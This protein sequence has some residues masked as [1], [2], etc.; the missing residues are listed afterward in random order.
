MMSFSEFPPSSSQPSSRRPRS[1]W[2][3]G[4]ALLALLASVCLAGPAAWA[5][6]PPTPTPTIAIDFSG[7]WRA[8][9]PATSLFF[10]DDFAELSGHIAALEPQGWRIEA[11][12]S[13]E[14]QGQRRFAGLFRPGSGVR[15][16]FLDLDAAAFE[17]RRK[18]QFSAGRRLV[19][20]EVQMVGGQR[21]YSGLWRP[22]LGSEIVIDNLSAADFEAQ[23][24]TYAGSYTIDADQQCGN[25]KPAD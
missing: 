2:G 4:R 14:D 7:L 3:R 1:G 10:A 24:L 19:D 16:I 25:H 9:T 15:E 6:P 17:A 21:R 8:D 18:L 12:E 20:V 11:F 5:D 22:G 13:W 23:V